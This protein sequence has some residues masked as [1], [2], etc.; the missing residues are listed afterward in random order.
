MPN[1]K[2][3]SVLTLWTVARDGRQIVCRPLVVSGPIQIVACARP[4]PPELLTR[5]VPLTHDPK[6]AASWR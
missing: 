3:S 4:V 6:E 1:E 5:C 2:P